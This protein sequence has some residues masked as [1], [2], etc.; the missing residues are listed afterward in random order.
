MPAPAPLTAKSSDGTTQQV[1]AAGASLPAQARL[2]FATSRP[3][4]EQIALELLEGDRRVAVA[5]FALPRGL[6]ANCWIP[7]EIGVS[8]DLRVR[9]EAR[10][11]LRRIRV[12]ATFDAEGAAAEHYRV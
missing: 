1:V 4:Q 8:A 3:G 12:D 2:V 7:V 10:E 11:N 9:A 5:T 6:P